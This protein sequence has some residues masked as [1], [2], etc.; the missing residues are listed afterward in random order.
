MNEFR[1]ALLESYRAIRPLLAAPELE[2]AWSQDSVLESF[3]VRGLAGH[4]V[5]AGDGVPSYLEGPEPAGPPADAASYYASVLES[6]DVDAHADVRARAE[7]R[8]ADGPAE[9]RARRDAIESR[10]QRALE[11]APPDRLVSVFRG[12]VM[13]LD[14]YAITRTV[15]V[16]VHADD[17]AASIAVERPRFSAAARAVCIHHLVDVARRRHGDFAVLVA[18]ARR[19]R[20]RVD[21]LRVFTPAL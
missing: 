17:L 1:S 11:D 5:R 6:M 20:D 9:L 18:L 4:L 19:E 8:A 21:A 7:T 2:R 12:L 3:S 10:L 16:L 13:R 14:D 15:E